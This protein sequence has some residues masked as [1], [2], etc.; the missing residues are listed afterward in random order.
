[1][2]R[3][4]SLVFVLLGLVTLGCNSKGN[5]KPDLSRNELFSDVDEQERFK[6]YL[7]F[8]DE[9]AQELSEDGYQFQGGAEVI[10]LDPTARGKVAVDPNR[11][12]G[13]KRVKVEWFLSGATHADKSIVRPPYLIMEFSEPLS[14][15]LVKLFIDEFQARVGSRIPPAEIVKFLTDD[16]ETF[17]KS[18]SPS[19]RRPPNDNSDQN[20]W[21]GGWNRY[22]HTIWSSG[23]HD[24]YL[25]LV[26]IYYGND[27][28]SQVQ[29][30]F[31]RVP[32]DFEFHMYD[33]EEAP[34]IIPEV[35]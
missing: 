3:V 16:F 8:L 24:R 21:E 1:M 7:M 27:G 30:N 2:P 22:Q 18:V 29:I 15:E 26:T 19:S 33:F 5:E 20:A 11:R 34:T 25:L 12:I 17:D 9:I 6:G 10:H 4:Q 31:S 32:K 35:G 28:T 14:S 23:N 13:D